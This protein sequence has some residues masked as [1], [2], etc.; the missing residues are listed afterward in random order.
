MKADALRALDC[1]REVRVAARRAVVARAGA[2]TRA[3][4]AEEEI[5]C[6]F[7]WR[8]DVRE[9]LPAERCVPGTSS[10]LLFIKLSLTLP[11][12]KAW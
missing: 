3:A 10:H 5:A 9:V 2:G 12:L 7:T 4:T 1:T 8:G 6:I 11:S